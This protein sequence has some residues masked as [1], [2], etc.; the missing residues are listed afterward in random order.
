MNTWK[1]MVGTSRRVL[2]KPLAAPEWG[3]Q[4]IKGL[5]ISTSLQDGSI[6]FLWSTL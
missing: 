6:Y 3:E 4:K 5:T 1:K 2:A